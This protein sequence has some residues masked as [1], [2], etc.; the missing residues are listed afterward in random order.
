MKIIVGHEKLK[1]RRTFWPSPPIMAA[2]KQS[3]IDLTNIVSGPRTKKGRVSYVEDDQD[4]EMA[5]AE[6]PV[7]PV[8]SK[9]LEQGM[10]LWNAVKNYKD[11]R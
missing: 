7:N 10:R 8:S 5:D 1:L 4:V 11:P 2:R 6:E 9:V 3:N